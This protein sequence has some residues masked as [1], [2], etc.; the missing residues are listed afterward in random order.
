MIT[1]E[2][3]G[4]IGDFSFVIMLSAAAEILAGPGRRRPRPFNVCRAENYAKRL[5][6]A[7]KA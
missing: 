4:R 1:K 7:R 6:T 5:I 2:K 3:Y